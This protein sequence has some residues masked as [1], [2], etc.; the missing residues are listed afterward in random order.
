MTRPS[1]GR[2]TTS[3]FLSLSYISSKYHRRIRILFVFEPRKRNQSFVLIEPRPKAASKPA[4]A[5]NPSTTRLHPLTRLRRPPTTPERM[6]LS[7]PPSIPRMQ[8]SLQS[9]QCTACRGGH[10]LQGR[11]ACGPSYSP[12]SAQEYNRQM[13]VNRPGAESFNRSI[14]NLF[15]PRKNT[16]ATLAASPQ[17]QDG[18]AWERRSS[19]ES[20]SRR[21]YVLTLSLE[22]VPCRRQLPPPTDRGGAL[23]HAAQA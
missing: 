4:T 15:G 1:S 21:P 16:E 10:D 2:V 5:P 20:T 13:E 12:C 23:I 19:Q 6:L 7:R 18:W 22:Q 11:G 8:A 3:P 14:D 9:P 17:P